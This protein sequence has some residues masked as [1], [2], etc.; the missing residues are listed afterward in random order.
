MELPLAAVK[1]EK[2]PAV[3]GGRVASVSD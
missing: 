1:A 3:V 2:N